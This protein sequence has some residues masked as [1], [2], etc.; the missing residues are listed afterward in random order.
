MKEGLQ[1]RRGMDDE[2]ET[3]ED[4]KTGDFFLAP[5]T[6]YNS[7]KKLFSVAFFNLISKPKPP[8]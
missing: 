2:K 4:T 5:E 7:P 3:K 6:P 1:K 8:N